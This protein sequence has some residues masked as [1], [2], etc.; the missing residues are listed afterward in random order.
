MTLQLDWPPDVV[1]RLTEEARQ[2]G[3]SL[4]AYLLQTILQQKAPNGESLTDEG[5]KRRRREEAAARIRELRKGVTL[6]PGL[7]IRDLINEG[8]RD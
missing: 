1:A 7:T 5:E 2:K 3:L 4:D 8:R 6:G